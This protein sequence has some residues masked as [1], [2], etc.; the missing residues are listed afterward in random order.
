MYS[1]VYPNEEELDNGIITQ[2]VKKFDSSIPT[3]SSN[4]PTTINAIGMYTIGQ[5]LSFN[6]QDD[7]PYIEI[8]FHKFSISITNYIIKFLEGATPPAEWE[9]LGKNK[10]KEK[11]IKIFSIKDAFDVC[12]SGFEYGKEADAQCGYSTIKQW[13]SDFPIG[14]FRFIKFKNIKQ[15]SGTNNS[16]RS[17]LKGYMRLSKIDFYGSIWINT[18]AFCKNHHFYHFISIISTNI[19][20]LVYIKK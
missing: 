9:I 14:P 7:I 18:I 19:F 1:Y 20:L 16:F 8:D 12:P 13:N 17:D 3:F 11:W 10:D 5:S 2:L 6:V 15:R 4:S